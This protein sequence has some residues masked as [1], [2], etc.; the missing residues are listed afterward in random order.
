MLQLNLNM[1]IQRGV[2]LISNYPLNDGWLSV[3][4]PASA[5]SIAKLALVL[6]RPQ[7]VHH[8]PC[9]TGTVA[10]GVSWPTW[11][12]HSSESSERGVSASGV[13]SAWGGA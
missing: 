3:K 7:V 1:Q 5:S 11:T 6:P 2:E 8:F 12:S 9:G 4:D 10:K 13:S